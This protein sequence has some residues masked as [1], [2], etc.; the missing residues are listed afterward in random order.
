MSVV[1]VPGPVAVYRE[2]QW[3]G[4]WVYALLAALMVLGGLFFAWSRPGAPGDGEAPAG[5][6]SDLRI[7]L[8][9]GLTL[10]PALLVGVLKMT[11]MVTPGTLQVWFGVFPAFRYT[12]PLDVIKGAQVVTYRPL[13]DCGGWGLRRSRMGHRVFNARGNR[14]VEVLLT[15]GSKLL[16]GSQRPEELAA[17]LHPSTR[18]A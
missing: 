3:F 10:P 8:L 14:A 4:W 7:L 15:D 18:A 13:R 11:T 17:S 5:L 16:I 2:E 12:V 9:V 6:S 1:S